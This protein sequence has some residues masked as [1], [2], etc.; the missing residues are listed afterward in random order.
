MYAGGGKPTSDKYFIKY[1]NCHQNRRPHILTT[2]AKS[3]QKQKNKE[4]NKITPRPT[5]TFTERHYQGIC[6]TI[7]KGGWDMGNIC[8]A[9]AKALWFS[10]MG[11]NHVRNAFQKS[12]QEKENS[13]QF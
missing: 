9:F 3:H 2:L 12:R 10:W 11:R 5:N 1:S 7:I 13:Y 6:L 4:T 8:A